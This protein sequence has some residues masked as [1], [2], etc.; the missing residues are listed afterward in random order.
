ML[1]GSDID[2]SCG[3]ENGQL[4]K[5]GMENMVLYAE[6]VACYVGSG[7]GSGILLDSRRLRVGEWRKSGGG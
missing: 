2:G 6:C 4:R 3:R 1:A 7:D 5:E